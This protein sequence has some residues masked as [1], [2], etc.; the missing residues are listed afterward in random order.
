MTFVAVTLC[1]TLFKILS[2]NSR[3]LGVIPGYYMCMYTC[4]QLEVDKL[5]TGTSKQIHWY[6]NREI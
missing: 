4:K 6:K 3:G 1:G 5:V 2:L